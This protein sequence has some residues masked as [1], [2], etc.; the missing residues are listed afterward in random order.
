[1][2]P[3]RDKRTSFIKGLSVRD[4]LFTVSVLVLRILTTWSI[5]LAKTVILSSSI[6]ILWESETGIGI[7]VKS[8]K[9]FWVRFDNVGIGYSAAGKLEGT[10]IFSRRKVII[11]YY[12]RAKIKTRVAGSKSPNPLFVKGPPHPLSKSLSCP[13]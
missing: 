7:L 8:I 4:I 2:L 12:N 9:V 11:V 6:C 3:R 10:Q 5:L 13:S 1:M